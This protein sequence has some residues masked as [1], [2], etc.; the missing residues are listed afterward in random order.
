[1][2]AAR[3]GAEQPLE[4]FGG[5]RIA[6]DATRHGGQQ[7]LQARLGLPRIHTDA[8][9]DLFEDATVAQQVSEVHAESSLG[10][11]STCPG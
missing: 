10:M 2:S 9:R 8:A 5:A 1:M 3:E 7:G 11:R 6:L 4:P